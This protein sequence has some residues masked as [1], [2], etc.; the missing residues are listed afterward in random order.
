MGGGI[1]IAEGVNRKAD[2]N[3]SKAGRRTHAGVGSVSSGRTRAPGSRPRRGAD[4]GRRS[5]RAER[6]G[7][8]PASPPVE[9]AGRRSD[10]A[11][12]RRL[13]AAV[14]C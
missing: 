1:S 3:V 13:Q 10:R 6:G 5:P 14:F 11:G 8:G 4:E 2:R 7:S 12:S 9:P